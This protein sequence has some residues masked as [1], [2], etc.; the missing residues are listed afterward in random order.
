MTNKTYLLIVYEHSPLQRTICMLD[1]LSNFQSKQGRQNL[2]LQ[3]KRAAKVT[4]FATIS[5]EKW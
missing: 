2:L 1:S 4:I 5:A 3:L